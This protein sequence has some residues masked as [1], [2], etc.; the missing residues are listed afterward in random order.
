MVD[1]EVS[2]IKRSFS[3]NPTSHVIR[4]C[5]EDGDNFQESPHEEDNSATESEF[6][7][8][9]DVADGNT[10]QIQPE[11]ESDHIQGIVPE[12]C[13]ERGSGVLALA[14]AP[15]DATS[16]EV[17]QGIQ[18]FEVIWSKGDKKAKRAAERTATKLAKAAAFNLGAFLEKP[19]S[20]AIHELT[21]EQLDQVYSAKELG[22]RPPLLTESRKKLCDVLLRTLGTS[23]ESPLDLDGDNR[24]RTEQTTTAAAEEPEPPAWAKSMMP[25]LVNQLEYVQSEVKRFKEREAEGAREAAAIRAKAAKAEADKKT[26][27]EMHRRE[28]ANLH[29]R[30]QELEANASRNHSKWTQERAEAARSQ[31]KWKQDCADNAG[32]QKASAYLVKASQKL[33]EIK[34]VRLE[35]VERSLDKLLDATICHAQSDPASTH[36]TALENRR[37]RLEQQRSSHAKEVREIEARIEKATVLRDQFERTSAAGGN[38]KN[39]AQLESSTSER[40]SAVSTFAWKKRTAASTAHAQ[41]MP[42]ERGATL[43]HAC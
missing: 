28:V 15:I 9:T 26:S 6:E 23:R 36:S 33:A 16:G 21:G 13:D 12:N 27:E 35:L 32:A 10:D 22:L 41:P 4:M 30:I 29:K 18:R 7:S 34:T 19:T 14:D 43:S 8:L 17:P 2:P 20:T 37:Q 40:T 5:F 24:E 42:F 3:S 31:M 25:I 38:K 39:I 1:S 11:E